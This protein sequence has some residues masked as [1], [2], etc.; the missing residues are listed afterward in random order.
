MASTASRV[1]AERARRRRAALALA[2]ERRRV[3]AC[4]RKARKKGTS[5]KACT[6]K[7]PRT[8]ARP[9]DPAIT[10]R[11][12]P[13]APSVILPAPAVP[14]PAAPSTAQPVTA[15]SVPVGADVPTVPT[16]PPSTPTPTSTPWGP[17]TFGRVQATRLLWRAGFGPRP[18]DVDRILALGLDGAI[19]ELVDPPGVALTGAAPRDQ[20]G[21]ALK[22]TTTWGHDQLWWLDRMVRSNQPLVERMT[23]IWHD[24]FATSN[25]KVGNTAGMLAQNATMRA[26]A[27]GSFPDLLQKITQDPAMLVYLDGWDN[28]KG[29]VNE[30]YGREVMELFTL[31]AGR[32]AYTEQDVR[33]ISRA[34]TGLNF[35]TNADGTFTPTWTAAQAD[36]AS[37]TIFG[38]TG[39]FD[40]KDACRLLV[41]HEQHPSFLA[42]KLWSSFVPTAPDAATL[43][44]LVRVYLAND[45]QVKPV[46]RAILSHP[47]LHHGQAMVKPPAVFVAGLLRALNR[48]IDVD[49]WA[50]ILDLC[51]QVLFSPPNVSGWD[52]TRWM[53]SATWRGRYTAVAVAVDPMTLVPW[54]TDVVQSITE[55]PDQAVDRA[56]AFWGNPPVSA[57]ARRA[58]VLHAKEAG[59]TPTA[60]LYKKPGF[61]LRQNGLRLLVGSSSDAQTS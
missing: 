14:G 55:T 25:A 44:E 37:K 5:V 2:K 31:G 48:T 21:G 4:K 46:V 61:A 24:W 22:P 50:W 20:N 45:R 49:H 35:T 29:H 59:L 30:N 11:P 26:G 8:P 9:A 43:A 40:W 54:A 18:G 28:R 6:T 16:P 58:L 10:P 12:A 47:D 57:D 51:G 33:E 60:L 41:E 15:P 1:R 39:T 27:L 53:N 13:T 7:K 32:G 42:A 19:D 52:D 23:L 36:R 38:R 17:V 34:F 56:L 3:A